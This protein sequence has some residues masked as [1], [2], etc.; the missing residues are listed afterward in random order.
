MPLILMHFLYHESRYLIHI[1][2]PFQTNDQ[3]ASKVR[4]RSN[5]K[6]H[7]NLSN[8]D[9]SNLVFK[10]VR[11]S[12]KLSSKIAISKRP[13]DSKPQ[14]LLSYNEQGKVISD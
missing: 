5:N 4:E 1:F 3:G 6:S 12:N 10:A 9:N 7:S 2:S 11:K 13:A 14:Q 8:V